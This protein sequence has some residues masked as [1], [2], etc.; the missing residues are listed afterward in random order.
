MGGHYIAKTPQNRIGE[1]QEFMEIPSPT[2]PHVGNSLVI[3]GPVSLLFFFVHSNVNINKYLIAIINPRSY[4]KRKDKRY[5]EFA[6]T[7]FVMLIIKKHQLYA[8]KKGPCPQSYSRIEV[9]C[10]GLW[11]MIFFSEISGKMSG[12]ALKGEM[13]G[14]ITKSGRINPELTELL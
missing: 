14:N 13:R 10:F 5:V 11:G 12:N 7:L 6:L 2:V 9:L 3:F 4:R 8:R 1:S